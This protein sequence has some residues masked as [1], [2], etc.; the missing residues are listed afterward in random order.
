LINNAG[1]SGGD[2]IHNHQVQDWDQTLAVNLRGPFLTS[3]AVL[4]LDAGTRQG[5][6]HQHQF[7]VWPGVLPG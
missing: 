4:P 7:R 3:R 6:H 5:A 2:F 1:I